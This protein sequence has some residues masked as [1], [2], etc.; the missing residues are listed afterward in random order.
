MLTMSVPPCRVLRP[1]A[2]SACVANRVSSPVIFPVIFEIIA[3]C[4][5]A[6]KSNGTAQTVGSAL[7]GDL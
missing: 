5:R 7:V 2:A 6:G 1:P 3:G 4:V